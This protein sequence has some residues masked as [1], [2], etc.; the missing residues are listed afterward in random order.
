MLV[1]Y[2]YYNIVN[3]KRVGRKAAISLPYGSKLHCFL[4][5]LSLLSHHNIN[6]IYIEEYKFLLIIL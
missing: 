3:T 2:I 5:V 1:L 4:S 6:Y